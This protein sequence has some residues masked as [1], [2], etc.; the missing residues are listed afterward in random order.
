[1]M[2]V[3]VPVPIG[4]SP[5][6]YGPTTPYPPVAPYR[7][8]LVSPHGPPA[9]P[10][11]HL[12]VGLPVTPHGVERPVERCVERPVER[13]VG[14]PSRVPGVYAKPPSTPEMVVRPSKASKKTDVKRHFVVPVEKMMKKPYAKP[15]STPEMVVQPSKPS[16]KTDVKRHLVVPVQKM[17]KK[18][19]PVQAEEADCQPAEADCSLRGSDCNADSDF[20]ED[21]AD[22]FD[23]VESDQDRRIRTTREL[24]YRHR[25]LAP[26]QISGKR[27]RSPSP[28]EPPCPP[29][30]KIRADVY[31][32]SSSSGLAKPENAERDE[33]IDVQLLRYSQLSIKYKFQDGRLISDL[34]QDLLDRKVTLFAPFLRLSIAETTDSTGRM[35]L[36]CKDNRRLYALKQYAKE[37]GLVVKAFVRRF[38]LNDVKEIKGFIRNSDKTDGYDIIVRKNYYRRGQGHFRNS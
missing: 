35:V 5:F 1:M 24:L 28:Q 22:D 18:P 34:V 27:E 31:N 36:K 8:V 15:P 37:S 4:M 29:S 21:D 17:M 13:P 26:V 30:K 38:S 10:Y 32:S 6:G 7:H 3:P 23:Q 2:P 25:C 9:T 16:K 19:D 11:G 12:P 20:F 14:I 33:R